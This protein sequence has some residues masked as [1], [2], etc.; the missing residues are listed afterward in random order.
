MDVTLHIENILHEALGYTVS[1]SGPP[2]L[3][4]ALRYA[5][6]PGGARVRPRLT[7]AVAE[8]CGGA[9][10][11][12]AAAAAAAIEIL[13]CA[14]LVHDDLPCFDDA[15]TRRGRPSV[16]A[17]FGE[18]IAV[19]AGD[20]LIVLAF[21][22]V[23]RGGVHAP[24]KLPGVL[25]AVAGGVG[26]PHG[27][28]A[29][30]AWE[31]EPS[32]VLSQYQQAKTGALFAAATMAGCAA[33]SV[34]ADDDPAAW[35]SLGARLGEAYQVADDLRDVL[36]LTEECGKPVG[37][38]VALD[39]PSSVRELG[40]RGAMTQLDGLIEEVLDAIP[41]CPGRQALRALLLAESK[42]FL[43]KELAQRAA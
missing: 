25:S 42:R 40:V 1:P 31:C 17:R 24:Q 34:S 21:E 38:D 19:L 29:G 11:P 6:L 26:S 20:A 3:Q 27:I 28:V 39:R 41:P 36:S 8:A 12:L 37:R 15:A 35:R 18:R 14:S 30:Q 9:D 33:G 16:H 2:L 5:V 23:A 4:E 43:S 7:L 22:C 10:R 13:H 32:V